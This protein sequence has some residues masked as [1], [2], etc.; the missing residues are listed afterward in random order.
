MRAVGVKLLCLLL[1]GGWGN[2]L[3]PISLKPFR[4]SKYTHSGAILGVLLFCRTNFLSSASNPLSLQTA[5]FTH[6]TCVCWVVC[7]MLLFV[8]VVVVVVDIG[9]PVA[10]KERI[11]TLTHGWC[12]YR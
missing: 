4:L 8:V 7:V 1:G 3:I 5:S 6:S 10:A 11:F 9:F 2:V 12:M